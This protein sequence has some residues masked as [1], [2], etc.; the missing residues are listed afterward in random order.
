[1]IVRRAL[2]TEDIV[3][4]AL[5]LSATSPEKLGDKR[6]QYEADLRAGLARLSPDGQ[7]TE[8]AELSALVAWRQ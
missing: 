8:I 2:T 7:F 3:G 6:A 5:S 1:V 4:R